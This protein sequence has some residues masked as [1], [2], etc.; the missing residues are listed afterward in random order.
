M[1]NAVWNVYGKLQSCTNVQG[2]QIIYSYNASG[3][4]ISKT[5]DGLQEWYVKDAS[6]NEIATYQMTDSLRQTEVQ[7][8]GSVKIGSLET[9]VN[10]QRLGATVLN[11]W[12]R[13]QK[14]YYLYNYKQDVMVVISDAVSQKTTNNINIEWYEALV[15]SANYYTSY[16]A[17]SKTV[18]NTIIFGYN[19]QR[20]NNEISAEA[21]TAEFWE[22][23]GE[24]AR[25]WN[26]DPVIKV[27]ESPYLC[28]NGNPILIADPNGDDGNPTPSSTKEQAQAYLKEIGTLKPNSSWKKIDPAKYLANIQANVNNP[29]ILNQGSESKPGAGDGTNFCGYASLC[30]QWIKNDPLGYAKFMVDMYNNGG[31]G[32]TYNGVYVDASPGMLENAGGLPQGKHVG[33]TEAKPLSEN[34]ADQ[35]MFLA[36]ANK[37]KDGLNRFEQHD[38]NPGDEQTLWASCSLG[39]FNTI[40]TEFLGYKVESVGSTVGGW[41]NI[42]QYE[43]YFTQQMAKGQVVLFVNGPVLR[44]ESWST[45]KNL[46][47]THFIQLHGIKDLGFGKPYQMKYWHYGEFVDQKVSYG[48]MTKM[49]YGVSTLIKQ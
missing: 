9:N 27:W 1:T 41:N 28:Y 35:V 47:P 43:T 13:K 3:Q 20:K 21:Q 24:V 4:R 44:N 38:Y 19:G 49:L 46:F 25:R 45:V 7:I 36:L 10:M 32:A 31:G 34:H 26:I 29:T 40:A 42:W 18:G 22:Y 14:R 23:N 11:C 15:L 8:Y 5:I 39:K 12:I 30:Q 48:N 2:K 16:G 37:Y 17:L 33:A 6:G